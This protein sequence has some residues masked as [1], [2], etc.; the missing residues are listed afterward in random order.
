[1]LYPWVRRYIFELI[2][3]RKSETFGDSDMWCLR[4]RIGDDDYIL[5]IHITNPY[6]QHHYCHDHRHIIDHI[7][8]HHYYFSALFSL[9]FFIVF[10]L[11]RCVDVVLLRSSLPAIGSL[12]SVSLSSW[13]PRPRPGGLDRPSRHPNLSG[14]DL[15]QLHCFFFFLRGLIF[16]FIFQLCCWAGWELH[17]VFGHATNV[18]KKWNNCECISWTSLLRSWHLRNQ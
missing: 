18:A 16:I 5:A 7:L 13:C 15:Q 4:N 3:W 12:V 1:M 17:V 14:P 8:H 10:I 9:S 2:I 6:H 11:W